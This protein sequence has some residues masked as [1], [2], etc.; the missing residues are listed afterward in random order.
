ME[1]FS[2]NK[3]CLYNSP[4]GKIRLTEKNCF[5]IKVDFVDNVL[6]SDVRFEDI[7]SPVSNI[8]RKVCM[9]LDDYFSG[10]LRVF[11]LSL[12]MHGTDFQRLAWSE[13]LRI[14]YGETRSYLQQAKAIN[15][16]NAVRAIG[17]ANSKNPIPIII[18][19]HRVIGANGSL[20][21]YAGGIDRKAQ[22]LDLENNFMDA[23][24]N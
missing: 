9:Q 14:P 21:G 6:R 10:D 7:K 24:K 16:P 2:S 18:P 12:K 5:L 17:N 4:L 23:Q 3:T 19:C 15:Y 20:T 1:K 8:F 11:D 13:L 22:L